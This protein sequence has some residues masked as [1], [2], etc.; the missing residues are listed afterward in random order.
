MIPWRITKKSIG[1]KAQNLSFTFT[2]L[3]MSE[4]RKLFSKIKP[5][6]SS[7]EDDITMKMI[8]QARARIRA[9]TSSPTKQDNQDQLNSLRQSENQ[10]SGP[11]Q[12]EIQGCIYTSEGWR[13]VNVVAAIAKV[14]ERA[15][16]QQILMHLETN[17]LIGHSHHGAVKRKSTQSVVA[18]IHD[19]LL[20]DLHND[21]L[22]TR[23]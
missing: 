8:K 16:L 21:A 17:E 3:S 2:T 22:I 19:K 15:L 23:W 12:E 1:P 9:N 13:P 5:T 10:Q 4:F 11:H 6:K 20:E 14:I 7:G 18:E